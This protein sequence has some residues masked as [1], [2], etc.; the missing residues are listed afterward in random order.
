M[1]VN[2]LYINKIDDLAR[3]YGEL[4]RVE[5]L[6][7]MAYYVYKEFELQNDEEGLFYIENLKINEKLQHPF[8]LQ[9]LTFDY[10]F[11][12]GENEVNDI[13]FMLSNMQKNYEG[14]YKR[15]GK[16]RVRILNENV[17]HTLG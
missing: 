13:R 15:K 9:L 8:L 4:F 10:E 6:K 2:E 11:K 14:D 12:I 16:W 7:M 3:G 17:R 5:N 1:L